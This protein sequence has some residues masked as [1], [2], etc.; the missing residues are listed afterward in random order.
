MLPISA[1]AQSENL[2]RFNK[3]VSAD[4]ADLRRFSRREAGAPDACRMDLSH[5]F[6]ICNL[7]INRTQV[8][9]T[10]RRYNLPDPGRIAFREV[11]KIPTRRYG[12]AAGPGL[13][14]CCSASDLARECETG[15]ARN[16]RP[17]I[18]ELR[19]FTLRRI[20]S[21][22]AQHTATPE[23]YPPIRNLRAGE[24][25]LTGQVMKFT[26]PFGGWHRRQKH[27]APFLQELAKRPSSSFHRIS[28]IRSTDGPGPNPSGESTPPNPG[29]K[30]HHL[31]QEPRHR[32]SALSLLSSRRYGRDRFLRYVILPVIALATAVAIFFLLKN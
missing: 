5:L 2:E 28:H 12:L 16:D 4:C 32:R 26:V 6:F 23:K 17:E 29:S 27:P 25:L 8:T 20:A 11:F 3:V 7:R 14:Y 15:N 19:G 9:A 1:C 31:L 18:Q 30:A 24:F 22:G 21:S 13:F 10:V